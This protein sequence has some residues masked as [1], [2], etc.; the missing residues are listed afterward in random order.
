VNEANNSFLIGHRLRQ[1]SPIPN[2]KI[3]K[4]Q[5]SLLAT[6]CTMARVNIKPN[7]NTANGTAI[8]KIDEGFFFQFKTWSIASF[9][10]MIFP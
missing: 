4:Y 6:A 1:R 5:G 8:R 7:P 3:T 2:T 9:K 10:F